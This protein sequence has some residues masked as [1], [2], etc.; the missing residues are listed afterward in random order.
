VG[1]SREKVKGVGKKEMN[2]MEVLQHMYE[3]EK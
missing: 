3:I 1:I 2:M